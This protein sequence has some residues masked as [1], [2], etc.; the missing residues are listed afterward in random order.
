VHVASVHESIKKFI[1]EVC[2]CQFAL[3]GQLTRHMLMHGGEKQF[4][5]AKCGRRFLLRAAM[6]QHVRVVHQ[7]IRPH[8]CTVCGRPFAT[9]Y[10]LKM[11]MKTHRK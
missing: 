4:E 3:R 8:L 6:Y 2:A 11:H 10:Q 1:C 5:C 9:G 7:D